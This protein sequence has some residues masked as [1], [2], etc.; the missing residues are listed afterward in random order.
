MTT[1]FGQEN[2][3]GVFSSIVTY[4]FLAYTK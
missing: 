4:I 3:G 1:L 2:V